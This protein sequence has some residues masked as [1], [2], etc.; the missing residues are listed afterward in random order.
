MIYDQQR[1]HIESLLDKYEIFR[2]EINKIKSRNN[3]PAL[4]LNNITPYKTSAFIILY[5]TYEKVY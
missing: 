5:H 1:L 3:N 4:I 2:S